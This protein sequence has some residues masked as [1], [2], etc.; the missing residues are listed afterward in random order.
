MFFI[1]FRPSSFVRRPSYF[2]LI[3]FYLFRPSSFVRR[4]WYFNLNLF[5]LF[6]SVVRRP[7]SVDIHI[8][9]WIVAIFFSASSVVL[10]RST[11][12]FFLFFFFLFCRLSVVLRRFNLNLF[13]LFLSV[14]RRPSSVDFYISIWIF[15][16][17]FWTPSVVLRPSTFIFLDVSTHPY[18]RFCLFV[19]PF[20]R[21]VGSSRFL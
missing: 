10:R 14:V 1:L 16:I 2:N 18:K 13:Y 3:F 4:H 17:F 8:L 12:I 6:L 5:N 15:S 11:F 7:S 21:S 20:G 9:V 19:R